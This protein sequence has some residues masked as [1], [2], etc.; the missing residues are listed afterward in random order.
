MEALVFLDIRSK[1]T[2]VGA[3]RR[4]GSADSYAF[5]FDDGY[6]ALSALER[7]VL[8]QSFLDK[9]RNPVAPGKV[10][11]TK[12][13]PWF[14]NLLPEGK[15][16]QVIAAQ[17]SFSTKRDFPL[18]VALGGDLP[19]AVVVESNGR[20]EDSFPDDSLPET[21]LSEDAWKF[22]LS[23]VYLKFSAVR[24]TSGGLTVP[25][26]G[27]GG[28]WIVKLPSEIYEAVPENEYDMM[29]FAEKVGL[30]IPEIDLVPMGRIRGL[31]VGID[32]DKSAFVIKRFDRLPD[33]GRLHI[34]D[35]AQVFGLYP[36]EK[37]GK[38]SYGNIAKVV[39]ALSGE[40]GL[41]EFVSRLV[42]SAAIGNGDMHA[43]NW[44]LL[45]P[46]GR[47]PE[48]SP[49]YDFV[50]TL[51]Y[52]PGKET[53]GLSIA[54]TNA[55]SDLSL[56]LLARFAEKTGLPEDVILSAA[57]ETAL[58]IPDAWSDMRSIASSPQSVVK[59]IDTHMKTVPLLIRR[60]S[61]SV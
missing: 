56:D 19:G 10:T 27:V 32:P 18:I 37:Y 1:K 57:K 47:T 40:N 7:P 23:G 59:S 3:I 30:R 58:R 45:Y 52:V 44:S 15:L 22:S 20:R 49:P 29:R 24:E 16:R 31:P 43:K 21:A 2:L 55:F 54:G 8:G 51:N 35:F 25:A 36:E 50:S 9:N 11:N 53:M 41:K 13:L 26:H 6:R 61:L 42:I 28:S 12:L 34:E 4:I 33:G 46:D 38:I 17:H 14:S 5:S 39:Y 48:L 60:V